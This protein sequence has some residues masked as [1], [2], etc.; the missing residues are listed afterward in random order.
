MPGLGG[1]TG[2]WPTAYSGIVPNSGGNGRNIDAAFE[3][4]YSDARRLVTGPLAGRTP[5]GSQPSVP[6]PP[7]T[8]EQILAW[9]DAHW[10][11]PAPGPRTSPVPFSEAPGETWSGVQTA[12][13]MGQRG[14]SGGSG[15]GLLLAE[16]RA[17]RNIRTL[18]NLER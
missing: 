16:K 14:L 18:P 2:R 7:L 15:L 3:A 4:G 8:E 17:V 5:R 6:F 1:R 10:H 12:L 11:V 13:H 9:A